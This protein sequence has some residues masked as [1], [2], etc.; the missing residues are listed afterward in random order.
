[1]FPKTLGV[2]L[3]VGSVSYLVDMPVAFLAPDLSEQIHGFLGIPPAIAEVS[4]VLY[5]LIIGVKTVKPK[6]ERTPN[7]RSPD[8]RTPDERSPA[9]A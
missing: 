2:V 7:E 8:E 1:M 6:D 3:V 4:M 9:V 5:L